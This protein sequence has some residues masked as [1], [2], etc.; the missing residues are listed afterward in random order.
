MRVTCREFNGAIDF[1]CKPREDSSLKTF[2]AF[3]PDL[4]T[5]TSH[6]ALNPPR[7]DFY[8]RINQRTE[9]HLRWIG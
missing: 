7:A 3:P 9:E 2:A 1:I 6:L 4:A 5:P 8:E